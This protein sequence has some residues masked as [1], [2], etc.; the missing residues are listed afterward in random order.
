MSEQYH[1]KIKEGDVAP[2]VL[3]PGDPKRVAVVASFW[4]DAR[5]VAD[6]R[7]HITYTGT[8]KGVPIS[9]TSTGMGCPSTAIAIEELARCG[10]KNFL[11]IGTCGT[12]QDHVNVGDLMIFDS[13]CRYDGTSKQYAP[14][15]YP[16]VA[17]HEVVTAAI[18][19]ARDMKMPYHVGTTR[20][21]DTFYANY[22]EPGGSFN[23]FWQ[24]RWKEFY[25]DLKRLNVLGGEME[26][27]II[28]V[29]TR[30]WGLRGGAVAVNLDN[31]LAS[32]DKSNEYDPSSHLDHSE[33]NI[34]TLSLL[35][36][37]TIKRLYELDQKNA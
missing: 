15:E 7:E 11:R 5:L 20:T 23:N 19:A 31:I 32:Q 12:F 13:A 16:A 3:L 25:K 2:Y 9:C 24:S 30:I 8:Y 34:K 14:L 37:E 28:L 22:P 21:Q 33:D 36:C 26:T 27:S 10:V 6:N 4:D 18:D 1:L 17:D 35:G 29:L